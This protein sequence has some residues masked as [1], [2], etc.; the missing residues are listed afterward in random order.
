MRLRTKFI[1]ILCVVALIP[2]LMSTL[3]PI[4]RNMDKLR[5]AAEKFQYSLSDTIKLQTNHL[6]KK[7]RDQLSSI[8]FILTNKDGGSLQQRLTLAKSLVGGYSVVDQV[9]IFNKEG[10]LAGKLLAESV[11]HPLPFP[12]ALSPVILGDARR[13]K[14]R[15]YV[16]KVVLSKDKSAYLP[17]VVAIVLPD[18]KVFGYLWTTVNLTSLNDKV[19][20]LSKY[21]FEGNPNQIF[22]VDTS[23]RILIHA[24]NGRR[25]VKEPTLLAALKA[26]KPNFRRSLLFTFRYK[27]SRK[28]RFFAILQTVDTAGLAIV[29][30]QPFSRVYEIVRFLAKTTAIVSFIAL[31]FALFMGIW[32][33]NRLS[34]P[35]LA[36]AEAASKVATG[37]FETRVSIASQDEVGDMATAFNTMASDLEGYERQLIQETELRTNISRYLNAEL[38]ESVVHNPELLQ[39]GGERREV[40]ILFADI[41]AF[42]P[43][44]E[45]HDAEK[46]VAILNE[47]FTFVTE[48][49]FKHGGIID[50]FIGDCVMAVFGLPE[51]DEDTPLQAMQAAEDIL[52]WLEIGNAKWEEEL[53]VRLEMAIGINTGEVIAGNIGSEKR[54]EYTVIGHVV[55][56]A[57]HLEML[58]QP[59]QV[60]MTEATAERVEDDFDVVSLG[61]HPLP[62]RKQKLELYTLEE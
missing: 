2:L 58:A 19:A 41:V 11:K 35:I 13:S 62:G 6:L 40:T 20:T 43:L 31:I 44:I 61:V 56:T 15:M 29:V 1:L 7:S 24:N 38:I 53:G 45:K 42:T 50:K 39:L 37:N 23:F 47:L 36:I 52:H 16:G 12:K 27:D 9:G 28:K 3:I 4:P 32:N 54:M 8:G 30:Q 48:I 51:G 55:N 14:D 33:A 26:S 49:I 34:D 18:G 5:E 22:L 17:M 60:L 57:A 25:G 46:M 59:G 10:K 21:R